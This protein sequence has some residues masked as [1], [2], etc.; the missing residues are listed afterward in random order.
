M[1]ATILKHLFVF[2]TFFLSSSFVFAQYQTEGYSESYQSETN[3]SEY[4]SAPVPQQV[5]NGTIYYPQKSYFVPYEV[6]Q[7]K[8][9][10][11]Q[12]TPPPVLWGDDLYYPYQLREHTQF[13]N[14]GDLTRFMQQCSPGVGCAIRPAVICR[15]AGCT[16]LNDRMTKQYLFNALASIFLNNQMSR[17]D[18]CEADPHSR[19]C[20][21]NSIRF[22]GRVGETPVLIQIP[23]ATLIEMKPLAQLSKLSIFMSY[24]VFANGLKSRCSG[25][26]T[27]IEA[28][29]S[30][31]LIMR[32]NNYQCELTAGAPTT[33]FSMY[34]IDYIDLDYGIIGGFYSIG[35][36]GESAAGGTGYMLMKFKNNS[37]I[38]TE[39]NGTGAIIPEGNYTVKP[40]Q[41]SSESE[42]EICEDDCDEI[43]EE[44]IE[45][46]EDSTAE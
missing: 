5:V 9:E 2:F 43:I 21:S 35:L 4:G 11:P 46:E 45:V 22:G 23:S 34:N 12:I 39:F 40:Y 3:Y 31:Q 10:I 8:N 20:L 36:S 44:V 30:Q 24:D 13:D 17:I 27:S 16:R 15:R 38:S 41:K 19:A 37:A 1:E 28:V 29:S 26:L 6:K 42:E 18:I 25:A 32:D 33:A 7:N 14:Q